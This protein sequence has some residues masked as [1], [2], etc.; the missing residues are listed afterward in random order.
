M[1][2]PKTTNSNSTCTA[3]H[4][5]VKHFHPQGMGAVGCGWPM[6]VHAV[7]LD[8]YGISKVASA[9]PANWWRRWW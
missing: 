4:D 2:L 8:Y 3:P 7:P 1:V 6:V 5:L 9:T